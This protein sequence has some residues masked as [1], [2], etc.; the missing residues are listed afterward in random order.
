MAKYRNAIA[1]TCALLVS[2]AVFAGDLPRA[3]RTRILQHDAPQLVIVA[4]IV[5]AI[6]MTTL[7][8]RPASISLVPSRKGIIATR[9]DPIN[10]MRLPAMYVIFWLI[11]CMYERGM[12]AILILP[13]LYT[14]SFFLG[15]VIRTRATVKLDCKAKTYEIDDDPTYPREGSFNDFLGPCVDSDT[16]GGDPTWSVYL[17]WKTRTHWTKFAT[18]YDEA[19]AQ[20][21]CDALSQALGIPV[22]DRADAEWNR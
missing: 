19:E 6:W 17:R 8:A 4:L 7:R 15:A 3:P 9:R 22:M 16:D 12:P 11:Y 2:L 1:M 13:L 5:A 21:Q 20:R 18:Y 10:R 14:I